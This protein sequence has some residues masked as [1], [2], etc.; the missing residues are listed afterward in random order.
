MAKPTASSSLRA[1]FSRYNYNT[2]NLR[3]LLIHRKFTIRTSGN[4]FESPSLFYSPVSGSEKKWVIPTKI[5]RSCT[6]TIFLLPWKYLLSAGG[7]SGRRAAV[8]RHAAV[9]C[10]GPSKGAAGLRMICLVVLWWP[11]LRRSLGGSALAAGAL[12]RCWPLCRGLMACILQ[13]W[14]RGLAWAWGTIGGIW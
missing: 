5:L 9:R 2:E 7:G 8:W 6:R 4:H 10:A 1:Y 3:K 13:D 12:S 11:R 14:R